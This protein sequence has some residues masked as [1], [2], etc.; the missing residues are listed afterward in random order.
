M[1]STGQLERYEIYDLLGAGGMGEVWRAHDTKLNR[2][3]ALKVLPLE[4]TQDANRLQRFLREAQTASALN[5]QNI[6]T[7]Y[8]TG[9]VTTEEGELH[10]IA[11]EFIEGVTL[12]Q[13]LQYQGRLPWR[14]AVDIACQIAA[15]LAAAHRAHIVHR[16]IKPENVMLRADGVVKV[17]DF[18]LAKLITR[19][20]DFSSLA[21]TGAAPLMESGHTQPGMIIGTLRYMSP[22]QAR[23][24]EVTAQTDIF[25]LGALLYELLTG[26]PL[27]AG[28][29]AADVI[30]DILHKEAPSL[31]EAVADAFPELERVLHQ[32]LAK[33]MSA[34]YPT[35]RVMLDDLQWLKGSGERAHSTSFARRT[36]DSIAQRMRA[37][38]FALWQIALI[39]LLVLGAVGALW[40]WKFRGG[41]QVKAPPPS[42]LTPVNVYHWASMP[43]EGYSEGKF[44]PD[45]KWIAFTSTEKGSLNVWVKSVTTGDAQPSTTDGF[46]NKQ[47]LWSPN[48]DELAYISVRDGLPGIWRKPMLGG[49]PVF[50]KQLAA[51]EGDALLRH[52]SKN[53]LLYFE[54]RQNLYAFEINSG[55]TENL[56]KYESTGVL[57][58]HFS[59]SYDEQ[60][61]AY[62]AQTTDGRST[63]QVLPKQGGQSR[64]IGSFQA[65]AKNTA[66]HPDNQRFFFSAKV[67]GVFQ[68][69]VGD[70]SGHQP[71]QL[72]YGNTDSL[73]LDVSSDGTRILYGS[74]DERSDLWGVEVTKAREFVVAS[75]SNAEFWPDVAPDNGTIAYQSVNNLNQGINVTRNNDIMTKPLIFGT[76]ASL[77]VKEGFLPQWSPDGKRLAFMRYAGNIC[78][79]WVTPASGGAVQQLTQEGCDASDYSVMPYNRVQS[80]G[81]AWSPDGNRLAYFAARKGRRGLW[82]IN[83]GGT[84]DRL[85]PSI[86]DEADWQLDCPLWS[87]D[88]RYIAWGAKTLNRSAEG[89]YGFGI[90]V[91]DLESGRSTL[92]YRADVRLRLLGWSPHDES[93]VFAAYVKGLNYTQPDLVAVSQV[94]RKTK[95]LTRIAEIPL[96]YYL[97]L[98]LSP[99]HLTLAYVVRRDEKDNL[100]VLPIEGSKQVKQLTHN[101][102][103]RTYFSSLGW[104]KNSQAIYFGLQTRFSSLSMLTNFK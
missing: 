18:G 12:R 74:A 42:S 6:I 5:H 62:I 84:G 16:D 34:R 8:D 72:T 39:P 97:N 44:S 13:H 63:V 55:K 50:L 82:V 28:G 25:S 76:P 14:A 22:E 20:A 11:T 69:F 59:L 49:M 4:Y 54:W 2:P 79:L 23:G 36:N 33:D 90:G 92:V 73:V 104:A 81:Y 101:N 31:R 91:T 45:G 83:V 10:F 48:G 21:D 51:G 94:F 77:L 27:F 78:N 71:Q 68:I 41:N 47:Q 29:T 46:L 37:P 40:W 26:A 53:G 15:A 1:L 38:R 80:S 85:I 103:P 88:G 19:P 7:I 3:V 66:W 65:I 30:S 98:H 24:Q 95:G 64:A 93:L 100:W 96:A 17:L 89:K 70:V 57:N 61:I 75:D 9:Q 35:V 86:M 43:G 58:N 99:D 32:S 52:W 60:W 87:S 102:H 56:T 67:N